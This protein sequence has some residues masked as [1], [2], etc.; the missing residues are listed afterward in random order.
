MDK[1]LCVDKVMCVD[2]MVCRYGSIVVVFIV[3]VILLRSVCWVAGESGDFDQIFFFFER[4][5]SCLAK[6][7]RA[8]GPQTNRYWRMRTSFRRRHHRP[9]LRRLRQS[10]LS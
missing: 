4:N 8:R 6:D 9:D 7:P 10:V 2:M 5:Y 1:A 3:S